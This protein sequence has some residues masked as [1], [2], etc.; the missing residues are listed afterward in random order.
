MVCVTT[1][2]YTVRF[3]GVPL[4]MFRPTRGLRQ[5]DPLSPYLFL[6]VADGLS[7]ILRRD[8]AAG[9]MEGIKVCRRAPE[10]T[11]LLFAD[12]SLLFFRAS[13]AQ[14]GQVKNALATYCRA[15]GQMVNFD[16]CSILFNE[17]QD[18][19]VIRSVK[20]QLNVHTVRTWDF[21]PRKGEW[22]RIDSGLFLRG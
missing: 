4:D 21:Q 19:E 8:A 9:A 15:T 17:N 16:K 22:C 7:R 5:G 6:F 1:L 3:N 20:E 13:S 10:T 11:S 2:R 14:A 18:M 12:D